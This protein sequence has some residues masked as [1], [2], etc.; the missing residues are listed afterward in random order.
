MFADNRDCYFRY[1][2]QAKEIF[3]VSLTGIAIQKP[4][5]QYWQ[6]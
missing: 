2:L 6:V 3:L 5:M 4:L 1:M